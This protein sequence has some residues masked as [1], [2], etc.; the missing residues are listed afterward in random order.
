MYSNHI[1]DA[2]EIKIPR[3]T[4]DENTK[5]EFTITAYN[6]FGVSRS[7]PFILCVKDIGKQGFV[8]FK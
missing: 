6:Y 3:R 1:Q 2:E 5:Y 4:L 7:N 8:Y